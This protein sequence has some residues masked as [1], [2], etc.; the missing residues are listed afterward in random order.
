MIILL[1]IGIPLAAICSSSILFGFGTA[2]IAAGS[3][4]AGYQSSIGIVA[5][6]SYFA[7]MTSVAMN[8][9]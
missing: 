1:Y 7:T 3:L 2:G 8:I 4:A 9:W 5:A 6:G